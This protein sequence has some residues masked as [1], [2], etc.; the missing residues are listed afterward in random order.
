M[1]TTEIRRDVMHQI[2]RC[3][4]LFTILE[5]APMEVTGSPSSPATH[6]W[7]RQ[8]PGKLL[9]Q[10]VPFPE[11]GR[12]LARTG[13]PTTPGYKAPAAAAADN[14]PAAAPAT[15]GDTQV[16]PPPS[17]PPPPPSTPTLDESAGPTRPPPNE[18]SETDEPPPPPPRSPLCESGDT[19]VTPR[20]RPAA[21]NVPA[22]A[23]A[24][25]PAAPTR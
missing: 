15:S 5:A 19:Q 25:V 11:P 16:T 21:D 8:S 1:R 7:N 14:V 3:L 6:L 23:P 18:W 10:A 24:T 12:R 20:P 13:P 4:L 17:P 22:A 9:I 2:Q